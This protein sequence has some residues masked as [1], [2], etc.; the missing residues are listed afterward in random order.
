MNMRT[1]LLSILFLTMATLVMA[2]ATDLFISEY[3]EGTSNQKAIEIFN[4]TGAAVDLSQYSMKK[5]TNGAGAFGNEL[6]LTGTLANNDCYV[7][8]VSS[9]TGTTLENQPY[10]DLATTSFVMA[11]NGN[12]CVA[13]C[14]NGN[15]IDIVGVVDQPAPNWGTDL[16]LRRKPEVFMPVTLWNLTGEWDSLPVNT[17]TDLGVHTFN[18]GTTNPLLTISSPNGGEQWNVGSIYQIVWAHANF[19][20]P[21]KI[22][23]MNGTTPTTLIESAEDNGTWTWDI[24]TSTPLGADYKIK[25]SGP[26]GTPTDMSNASFSLIG[27]V[28]IIDVPNLAALRTQ[29]AD[30]LTS[31][32]LTGEAWVTYFRQTRN[33]KYLQDNTAGILIDDPDGIITSQYVWGDG[34]LNLK[35]KLSTYHY[36][37]LFTPILDPGIPTSVNYIF[38]QLVTI[39]YLNT[40]FYELSQELI[41]LNHVSFLPDSTGGVF[42]ADRS[43]E[44]TDPSGETMIFRTNFPEADYIGLAIPEVASFDALAIPYDYQLQVTARNLSDFLENN[45][46]PSVPASTPILYGNVPNPF[47]GST[48]IRF[49]AKS[50]NLVT[51]EVYNVKGQ[52]VATVVN[53]ERSTGYQSVNWNGTDKNGEKL[54]SGVYLYKMKSGSFSA[55]KKM[56]LM[57]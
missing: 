32:R 12:D 28:P 10:V 1:F 50:N 19:T 7:I 54:P 13:L 30:N 33:Q 41:R 16:T 15:P 53:N 42:V 51:I 6:T 36:Q 35:G 22:E 27:P 11:F 2:Q 14:K 4:G 5:Q 34:M 39:A 57:K 45:D 55:T 23:L 29:T 17:F 37:Y 8:V 49:D 9:T 3:V 31:Y 24:P 43:Y 26:N 40:H 38:P 46:D 44:I 56:I 21:V 20:G 52:K 48:T 47:S 25:I 18:G